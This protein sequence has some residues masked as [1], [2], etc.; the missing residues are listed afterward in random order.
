[1]LLGNLVAADPNLAAALRGV[2]LQQAGRIARG[3]AA[4]AAALAA[5]RG[6]NPLMGAASPVSALGGNMPGYIP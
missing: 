2:A 5:A 6:A 3:P 1:M 4:Y